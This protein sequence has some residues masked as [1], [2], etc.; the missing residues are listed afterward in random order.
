MKLFYSV[1]DL[2]NQDLSWFWNN[3]NQLSYRNKY[4]QPFSSEAVM[5]GVGSKHVN[6]RNSS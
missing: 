3:T 5:A 2:F 4:T 6:I 1:S